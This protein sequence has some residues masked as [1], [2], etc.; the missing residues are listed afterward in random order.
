MAIGAASFAFLLA[1]QPQRAW[2]SYAINTLYWLGI[3]R[4]G[5]CSRA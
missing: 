4:A 2:G 3:A 1:T 5:W